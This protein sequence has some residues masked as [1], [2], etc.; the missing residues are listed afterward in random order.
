MDDLEIIWHNQF[1][2]DSFCKLQTLNVA[3][4]KNLTNVFQSNMLA[5]FQSL[6]EL[7]VRNCG[8]LEEVFELQGPNVEGTH[9][10]TAIQLEKL[11]LDRL[12]KMKHVWNKDPQESFSFQNLRNV[13]AS[14]CESLKSL[15]P[16]SVATCLKRLEELHIFDCGVEQIVAGEEGEGAEAITRFVFPQ[17]NF[18][19]LSRLPR[20]KCF[21]PGRHSSEWPMLKKIR[22]SECQVD[23]FAS[24][25][26]SEA[27]QESQLDI[28]V[29]QSL[30]LVDEVRALTYNLIG[31]PQQSLM[32]IAFSN[33]VLFNILESPCILF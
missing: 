3:F 27:L 32:H 29:K 18:I 15:F 30:F 8:S 1:A 14:Y 22:V 19:W 11:N 9:A 2:V 16:A 31:C 10:V 20:L 26:L 6:V 23:I 5:R 7:T 12:P 33:K 4:C 21:Y 25:L 24:E 17:V 28:S 13:S